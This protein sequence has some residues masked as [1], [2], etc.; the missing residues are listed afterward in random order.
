MI[1]RFLGDAFGVLFCQ[2]WS[3]VLQSGARLPIHTL[4]VCLNVTILIVDPWQSSVCF[5]RSGVTRCTLFMVLS[6]DRMCQHGLHAV[7]WSHIGTLMHRLAAE[8]CNIAGLL[9]PFRCPSGTILLTQFSMVWDWRVSRAGPMF[10]FIGLSCSISTILFYSLS[11]SLLSVY[12]LVLWGWGLRTD[13]V[14]ITLSQPCTADL[15]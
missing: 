8:P 1:D 9:F 2:F 3:I 7:L 4:G 5:I 14:Y 11:F 6:L 12:R 10:F 15:F 13:R